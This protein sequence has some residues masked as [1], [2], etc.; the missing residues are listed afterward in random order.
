MLTDSSA[1]A[2][3]LPL[4][5]W[6]YL[7]AEGQSQGPFPVTYLQGECTAPV[8]AA[9][10]LLRLALGVASLPCSSAATYCFPLHVRR[11]CSSP[12]MSSAC[13][14]ACSTECFWLLYEP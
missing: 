14:K 3:D 10:G 11:Q 4:E 9:S 13:P 8:A 7:D 12:A 2:A 1:M 6:Y 5:G